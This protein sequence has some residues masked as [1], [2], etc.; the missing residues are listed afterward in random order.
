MGTLRFVSWN[1]H[2]AGSREKRLKILN[3][4]KKLQADVVLLQETHMPVTGLNKLKTPEFPNVFSACYNSRQRGVAI[5]IH[6]NINF[7]VLDTV[8]D[9][10]GRFLIVKLSILNQKLGIVSIYGPNVDDP[11]FFHGFFSALSEHLDCTIV[12]GGDLNLGLN[13]EMDRLNT[14]GTQRNWQSTNIIKQ[15]MS[16]FGLCDAWRSLHPNSKEYSFF[17]HV[18]H[19]YSRLDYFLIS[20]SLLSDISDTEIHPIAVSDHAPVSLTLMQKNNTTPSKNW[21]FNTSLLK[22]E[23]FIKY[24]KKEWT[25]Y[26][27]FNDIPGT[28]ASVLWE[29]GKAVMRGKIISFSSHK[30][31]EENKNIQELEKNIKSLEKAYVS[32]QDQEILN[33]LRKTKLELNEIIN[34]KTKFLVQRL[35]LQNY[36]HGNKSGQFLANQLKINKEK[37]TICAVKDLSGNTIYDLKK[38]NKIFRDFYE[39]LYTPQINPSKNEIDQFLDNITLPKLL[40]T[41]AMALDSPLMP[42]EL[43]EA[44]I[45]MPNNKA[46]GPDGFPAEFYKE[47]WTILAPVFHRMLQEIKEN[48]RL[49]PNMNSANISLLLKPGKDPVYPSSY[50]PI[51]LINVD[52]KIICKALSKRLEKITPLLI[53]PDQTGFIKGRHSSTNTRRLLNLTDYSCSKNIETIILSLDAEKAFDRVNWK[54]LFATLHKFGFGT[55]F[56]N[57][58]K[59]YIIPQ[60]LVSE[61]MIKHPPASVS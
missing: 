54:F 49:P 26:L 19:S 28:S 41:Q 4:L 10:E 2:G 5:L 16:D 6:K 33:N 20:S 37:T 38:I 32:H 57:W 7:T 42:G 39:T 3:Q 55:S 35:R 56:I 58:L 51:S 11:S 45:S 25:S 31:K 14:T 13:E 46:P 34:K 29:A 23:E 12:L 1:V 60:Q 61:Q 18:H 47:F 27:D 8:I 21:R 59:Y 15:Y 9:P 50:R 52:L 48:G 30:K 17:S 24:F 53:H 22:D 36:E 43:Q 40:D 44:L